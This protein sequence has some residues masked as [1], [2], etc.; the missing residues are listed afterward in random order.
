MSESWAAHEHSILS[1]QQQSM[2]CYIQ[3]YVWHINNAP[4][5]QSAELFV[6]IRDCHIQMQLEALMSH[7]T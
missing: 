3:L 4:F 6:S 2:I 5:V 1:M 7:L